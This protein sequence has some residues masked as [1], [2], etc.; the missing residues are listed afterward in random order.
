M[1]DVRKSAALIRLV[2]SDFDGVFTDGMVYT[3]QHGVES[4]RCSRRDSLGIFMLR[5]V[6]IPFVVVSKETNFVVAARCEK[7]EVKFYHGVENSEGKLAILK[8]IVGE[9]KLEMS[10]VAYIGDDVNDIEPM[11]VVGLPVSV[12][13]GHSKVKFCAKF[14]TK[15][16][17]GQHAVREVCELILTAQGHAIEY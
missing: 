7:M 11:Q 16:V 17:G 8:R 12:A 3:D 14:T 1:F 10:Q 13:D 9:M 6:G 5:K 4:V 2:V 15:A